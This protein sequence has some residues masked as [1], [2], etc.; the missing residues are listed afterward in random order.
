MTN[1]DDMTEAGY[2]IRP[3]EESKGWVVR[4]L[5]TRHRPYAAR[6]SE[7]P[8]QLGP[9]HTGAEHTSAELAAILVIR[10]DVGWRRLDA[11]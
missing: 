1:G 6:L 4:S 10:R 5:R 7:P 11:Y 9:T 2:F 3:C 8:G